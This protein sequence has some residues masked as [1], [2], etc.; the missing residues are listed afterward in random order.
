VYVITIYDHNLFLYIA[1]TGLMVI[2]SSLTTADVIQ[3]QETWLSNQTYTKL[4]DSLSGLYTCFHTSAMEHKLNASVYNGRP[5]GGTS[6]LIGNALS[7]LWSLLILVVH[8]L[9]QYVV[10]TLVVKIL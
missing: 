10:L 5:F 8:L 4:N 2:T 7:N 9:L 6:V 3:L 1:L